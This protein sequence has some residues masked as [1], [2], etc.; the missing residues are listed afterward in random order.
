[1]AEP[2]GG[3]VQWFSPDPRAILPLEPRSEEDGGFHMPRSLARILRRGTFTVTSDQAFERVIAACAEPRAD[4]DETWIDA[5]IM[6]AYTLLH[7]EGHAHSVEAWLANEGV[8]G[9]RTLVGGVYGVSIGGAFFAESMFCR[10][11]LGGTDASKVCLVKLVEHLRARGYTLLDVQI[12]NPHTARFGVVDIPRV[13][14]LRRLKLAV[15][16]GVSFA[17]I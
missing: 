13:R 14:Y 15:A 16:M 5:R 11:E 10:P 2:G 12:A 7:R 6:H 4:R 1:M 3:P 9:S 17:A 8:P